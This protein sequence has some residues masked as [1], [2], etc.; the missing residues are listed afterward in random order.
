MENETKVFILNIINSVS[1][2]LFVD[3]IIK[4]FKKEYNAIHKQMEGSGF[5]FEFV[6]S[7]SIRCDKV[8]ELN[9]SSY[10]EST[11]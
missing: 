5:S 6:G 1:S 11:K 8:N 10:I 2:D 9:V 7:L 3:D 4:P